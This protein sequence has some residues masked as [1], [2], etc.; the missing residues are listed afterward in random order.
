MTSPD[1]S[2]PAVRAS[3][4]RRRLHPLAIVTPFG[5]TS[6]SSG[7]ARSLK[8]PGGA[9]VLAIL[10]VFFIISRFTDSVTVTDDGRVFI[11]RTDLSWVDA[12]ILAAAVGALIAMIVKWWTF[13][14]WIADGAIWT[15]GGVIN[16]WRRRVEIGQIATID[17]STSVVQRLFGASRIS[18]ETTATD[19]AR[20][21][22]LLGCLSSRTASRLEREL[23]TAL[24]FDGATD[25]SH[26]F[27][28]IDIDRLGW[29][30]LVI[31]GAMTLQVIR[32]GVLLY[33]AMQMFGYLT[34]Q[35]LF[36]AYNHLLQRH[37]GGAY[38]VAQPAGLVVA[39]WLAST[40]HFVMAFSRFRLGKHEDWLVMETGVIRRT[41][42]LIRID[43]IQ[44]LEVTRSPLQRRFR[45][46]RAML[47]MRLPAY[48]SPSIYAMV[49]HPAVTDAALPELTREIAGMDRATA[50]AM[51]GKRV[52]R[53]TAGSRNAYILA[54]PIRIIGCAAALAILLLILQPSLWWLGLVL[55]P[56]ALPLAWA[57]LLAWKSAG[58]YTDNGDWLVIQRG[59]FGLTSTA[60]RIDQ[61]QHLRWSQPPFSG[62]DATVSLAFAV[63]TS[64]GAGLIGRILAILHRPTSPSIIRIRALAAAD[65]RT[66]AIASGFE[67]SLPPDLA[68][69]SP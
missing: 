47:R 32:A 29:W 67:R 43:A 58:W 55:L 62:P 15:S 66:L 10:L 2:A 61:I 34:D 8:L 36:D 3:S 23:V 18:I 20:A 22:V 48:G 45:R 52:R 16:R 63:A 65:A 39:F 68:A 69:E 14:W 49:L 44:G 1:G 56:L 12:L 51:C 27:D 53:L 28:A 35:S 37:V 42:R 30:D 46:K 40:L 13:R 54:G 17:R 4:R 38:L 50:E 31:S 5:S 21:D 33:A 9:G 59:V 7:S 6:G 11:Q 19:T 24:V 64:G 25:E 60:A 26:R 41:R 57:G